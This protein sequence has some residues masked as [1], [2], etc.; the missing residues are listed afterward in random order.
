MLFHALPGCVS[1]GS[2]EQEALNIKEAIAARLW[3]A[4]QKH[5]GDIWVFGKSPGLV[6]E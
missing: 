6:S 2:D 3:A 1:Q 5:L 4:N